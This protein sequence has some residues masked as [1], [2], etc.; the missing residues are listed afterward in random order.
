LHLPLWQVLS[1]SLVFPADSPDAM[2]VAAVDVTSY[3][4]ELYSS[5]GPIFGAGGACAG[6]NV[7]PDIASYAN[8]STVSYGV[9][10]FNGTSAATPHV[11]G[12]AALYMGAYA[13]TIG[14]GTLPTPAQTQAYLESN[15]TDLGAA[16]RDN[17]TG[18]GRLTLGTLTPTAISL[19]SI[20]PRPLSAS[21]TSVLLP[22]LAAILLLLLTLGTGLYLRKK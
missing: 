14:S 22:L 17:Q 16:G 13:A 15:A 6:G 11:A 2:S 5:E 12:A 9:G 3:A 10:A 1:R 4:Q 21:G 20:T 18:A 8:V 19:Q 7:E